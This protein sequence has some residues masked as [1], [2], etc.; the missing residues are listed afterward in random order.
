VLQHARTAPRRDFGNKGAV[1]SSWQEQHAAN[2]T[3]LV[4]QLKAAM[5]EQSEQRPLRWLLLVFAFLLCGRCEGATIDGFVGGGAA[6]A[7]QSR[8]RVD[9][10]GTTPLSRSPAPPA[11]PTAAIAGVKIKKMMWTIR[12]ESQSPGSNGLYSACSHAWT[13]S[14]PANGCGWNSGPEIC[15]NEYQVRHAQ[16]HAGRAAASMRERS[17]GAPA[18]LLPCRACSA[19]ACSRSG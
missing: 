6:A 13:Y 8:L 14:Q 9:T 16:R 17:G 5:R 10:R 1:N 12:P 19:A 11:P 18:G 15:H 2:R 3:P 7:M 4:A